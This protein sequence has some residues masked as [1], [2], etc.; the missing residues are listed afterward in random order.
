MILMT[1]QKSF[2]RV[3]GTARFTAAAPFGW[4]FRTPS[5]QA[6][7]TRNP[8]I[9]PIELKYPDE[10]CHNNSRYREQVLIEILP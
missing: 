5:S 7:M 6:G 4:S 3:V 8:R 9:K 1:A 10:K 2:R